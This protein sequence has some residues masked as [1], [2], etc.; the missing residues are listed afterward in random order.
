[1]PVTKLSNDNIQVYSYMACG[2]YWYFSIQIIYYYNSLQLLQI[3][4][5]FALPVTGTLSKTDSEWLYLTG[6]SILGT[7]WMFVLIVAV[8]QI[9]TQVDYNAWQVCTLQ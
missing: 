2:G 5:I 3:W 7:A 4:S 6:W 9:A 1:M 8:W